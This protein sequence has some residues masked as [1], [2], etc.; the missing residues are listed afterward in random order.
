M[1]AMVRGK[2]PV[3]SSTLIS[4][5]ILNLSNVILRPN[6][7]RHPAMPAFRPIMWPWYV[8][9]ISHNYIHS[10]RN[11]PPQKAQLAGLWH[12]VVNFTICLGWSFQMRTHFQILMHCARSSPDAFPRDNW[13]MC[14]RAHPL[15]HQRAQLSTQLSRN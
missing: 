15:S 8:T 1:Y 12:S 14:L 4:A 6:F 13:T 2:V 10:V 3:C 11:R 7:C 9:F 5:I